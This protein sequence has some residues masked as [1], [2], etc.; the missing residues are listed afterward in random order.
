MNAAAR[1]VAEHTIVVPLPLETAFMLFT[2]AGEERWVEGWQPRYVVPDDGRT[3][4]GMVFTT[5]AGA[6]FTVWTLADFDR[7]AHRSRYV[8]CT[9]A[10]R[11]AEVEIACRASA[12]DTTRVDV[13]YTVTALADDAAALAPYA[14]ERFAAMIDGWAAAIAARRDTL[15]TAPCR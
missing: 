3:A 9:P 5:G 6:E 8:R 13:R 1:L 2:P 10:L 15:L 4:R 7:A 14:G 11:L 12:Q